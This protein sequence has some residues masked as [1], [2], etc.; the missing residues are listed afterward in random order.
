MYR[1]CWCHP[2]RHCTMMNKQDDFERRPSINWNTRNWNKEW[3]HKNWCQNFEEKTGFL[4]RGT[5]CHRRMIPL[6]GHTTDM[7]VIDIVLCMLMKGHICWRSSAESTECTNTS[8]RSQKKLAFKS[9]PFWTFVPFRLTV[10]VLESLT[11]WVV[12]LKIWDISNVKFD[13]FAKLN[14]IA[15]ID[16]I[17]CKHNFI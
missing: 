11:F 1:T 3:H 5:A 7:G 14:P 6:G 13:I 8:C 9:Y 16:V 10:T 17:L 12:F 4:L 2:C 15:W